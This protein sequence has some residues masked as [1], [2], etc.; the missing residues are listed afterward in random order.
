ML[1]DA[2]H[3]HLFRFG[4][5]LTGAD[6]SLT[7]RPNESWRRETFSGLQMLI[8]EQ[9]DVRTVETAD[10]SAL[11]LGWAFPI[12]GT[13]ID[14]VLVRMI[15]G[16]QDAAEVLGA[17]SGRFCLVVTTEDGTRIF[18]DPFGSR[19]IFYSLSRPRTLASHAEL[20]AHHLGA[21]VSERAR[22]FTVTDGYRGLSV[23][24]LPGDCTMYR[25]IRCLV[26]NH[27]L[28][29]ATS[30]LQRIWPLNRRQTRSIEEFFARC[31]IYFESLARGLGSRPVFIGLTGGVDTR[32]LLA[33]LS[34]HGLDLHAMTWLGGYHDPRERPVIE[35][36]ASRMGIDNKYVV[37]PGP[38]DA[39]ANVAGRNGGNARGPSRLTSA[40]TEASL[41]SDKAVFVRGYGGE[42]MRG[43]YNLL[44]KPMLD[45]SS[46]EMFRSLRQQKQ[47]TNAWAGFREFCG[48][49]FCRFRQANQLRQMSCG[50]GLR[51]K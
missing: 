33:G 37:T 24:Y 46:R 17:I 27:A 23:K 21:E 22:E 39:V 51:P 15:A 44:K 6:N 13:T 19:S 16:P 38:R 20:L 7:R 47:G 10:G 32:F 1:S 43:F 35:E 2:Q 28:N 29:F 41:D 50:F 14:E 9:T 18:T 26:P 30:E 34:K 4:F 48:P 45:G 5:L 36:I 11:L 31:D 25:D 3:S 42:I 12:G 40:I 8:H 49:R